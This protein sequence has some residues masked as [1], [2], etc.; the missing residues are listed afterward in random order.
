MFNI[1]N[2]FAASFPSGR[3]S[4]H[5]PEQ[6]WMA[7]VT[8]EFMQMISIPAG[9]VGQQNSNYLTEKSTNEQHSLC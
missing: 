6:R 4:N 3:K 2:R 5:I 1:S 7:V 9:N 8:P